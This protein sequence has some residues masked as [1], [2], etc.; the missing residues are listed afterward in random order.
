MAKPKANNKQVAE[1][2]YKIADILEMQS[3]ARKPRAYR[4]AANSIESMPHSLADV[5]LEGGLK[6]LDKIPGIGKALSKKIEELL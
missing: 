5:Y 2:F 1:I 6:A 3:V 4:A